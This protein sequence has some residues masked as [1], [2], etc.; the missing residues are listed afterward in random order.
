MRLQISTDEIY[1]D[2]FVSSVLNE[3]VRDTLLEQRDLTFEKEMNNIKCSGIKA[4]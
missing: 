4:E 3:K 2:H 1:R